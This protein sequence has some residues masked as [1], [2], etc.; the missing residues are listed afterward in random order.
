M[1]L[2]PR[3]VGIAKFGRNSDADTAAIEDIWN[4][5]GTY[6]FITTAADMYAS[7]SDALDVAAVVT[8][9]GLDADGL[10]V[11]RS[12][13]LT[14]QT[15]VVIPGGTFS[16]VYRAYISGLTATVGDVYIAPDVDA[17][18]TG[19]VPDT[20]SEIKAKIDIADQQSMMAITTIPATIGTKTVRHAWIADMLVTALPGTPAS[21]LISVALRVQPVG[22]VFLTM[23]TAGITDSQP[24]IYRPFPK[25]LEAPPLSR[26]KLTVATNKDNTLVTGEFAV[27]YELA[28]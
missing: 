19:G 23:A 27:F 16:A 1:V 25:Y 9:T 3:T 14:G 2:D 5:G 11:T 13:T 12:V 10:E 21:T 24:I 6:T 28:D 15:Q 18:I 20:A 22:G 26:V 17:A 8:V 7:S 4:Q